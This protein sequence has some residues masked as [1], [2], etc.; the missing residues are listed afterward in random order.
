MRKRKC[1]WDKNKS[2]KKL[3]R[4]MDRLKNIIIMA[5]FLCMA[6]PT[7]GQPPSIPPK[8]EAGMR[9]EQEITMSP[10][11]SSPSMGT[12]AG[13]YGGVD[14]SLPFGFSTF[15]SFGADKTRAGYA[16]GLFGGYRFN[17]VLSAELTLKWGKTA[18]S[19]RD[20]CAENGHWLV[21]DGSMLTAP[22]IN[23]D[24]W[25]YAD[26]KSSIAMQQYSV[27]LNVNLFGLF[28]ATRQSRWTLEVSPM[29]AAVGT[30]A[31]I[32]TIADNFS[33]LHGS[34]EWHLGAGG[35]LQAGYA[36]TQ[37]LRLSVYSG[38][39]WLTG[40]GMDGMPEH[41]HNANYIWES[42]VRIGWTFG[43]AK[44]KAKKAIQPVPAEVSHEVCPE[45]TES[46]T[47]TEEKNDTA[48]ARDTVNKAETAVIAV[49]TEQEARIALPTVYFGFN[50]TDIGASEAD[51]LQTILDVLKEHPDIQVLVTGWCDSVGNREVN[52]RISRKRA[53]A[54]KDWLVSNG[55]ESGRI[56]T[57]GKGTDTSEP[58]AAKARRATTEK[59]GKEVQR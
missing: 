37:N 11:T 55:I 20:C 17:P 30:K 18:L 15:S 8:G 38:I 36:I 44:G 7:Q 23:G 9:G 57:T 28:A 47:V 35:N 46:P 31:T 42:G 3:K 39:T 56:R 5:L 50:R 24:S 14:V 13:F 12:E 4:Y 19:A 40:K 29:L 41:N 53:E 54:V 22:M 32:K 26:L 34:T 1:A 58:D 49:E 21:A 51:K 48:T 16:F 2:E 27:R 43:K 6:N 59:Q 52:D 25:D 10:A 45:K 33:V